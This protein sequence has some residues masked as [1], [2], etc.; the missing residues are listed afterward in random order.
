MRPETVRS[1]EPNR[2]TSIRVFV[3][4]E[5]S[6]R[7][8]NVDQRE[9]LRRIMAKLDRPV[10]IE[11]GDFQEAEDGEVLV[12]RGDWVFEERVVRVLV[13]AR[14][15]V[16][17][18]DDG[19]GRTVPVAAHVRAPDAAAAYDRVAGQGGGAASLPSAVSALDASALCGGYNDA[20]RKREAPYVLPLTPGS[21]KAVEKRMFAASYKGVTDVITKYVWP[22]PALWVTRLAARLG[23]SPNMVTATSFVMVLAAMYAFWTG[24]FWTGL[25]AAYVMVF[26]DT[27]DGKLARVTV[28]SSR[29]GNVF[30]HGIDLIHPPF[31]YW[32]WWVGIDAVDPGLSEGMLAW[33]EVAL[34]TNVVGYV[35]GRV[36]EGIFI[37]AFGFE[38]HVWKPIDSKMREITARRNPNLLLLTLS[39]PVA[40][41]VFGFLAVAVWTALCTVFHAARLLQALVKR[42]ERGDVEPWMAQ[43]A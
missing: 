31:W 16:L 34:A 4:G 7:P 35:V 1:C 42:A 37:N 14:D 24:A 26:L 13:D 6:V 36:I 39:L 22:W 25:A 11:D 3:V 2:S 10:R 28:T 8:W 23:L 9:R 29:W 32:A 17:V 20:L 12:I 30:D 19:N 33:C 5:D 18:A 21:R 38:M 15:V 41:P 40:G 27:V 43:A